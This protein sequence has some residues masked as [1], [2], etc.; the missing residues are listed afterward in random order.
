MM[1]RSA[2]LPFR[3]ESVLVDLEAASSGVFCHSI[4]IEPLAKLTW[5]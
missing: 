3:V 4:V 2:C 1:V 5:A